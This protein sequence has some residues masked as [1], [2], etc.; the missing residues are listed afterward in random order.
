MAFSRNYFRADK[1][2][3]VI[4][5]MVAITGF[6]FF[7]VSNQRA[8]LNF[9]YIPVLFSAY[10][11]G[12]R[13]AT[14]SSL[15]SLILIS[16]L[17]FYYPSTFT[18]EDDS[19]FY[20]W[21]DLA[22]W[23]GFL[24]ITGYFMGHLYEK[25]ESA[26][27]EIKKT[28]QGIIEMM[29]LIIDSTDKAAQSHSYKVS[30]ISGMI[31]RDMGLSE[32]WVENIRIAALLHDL[33]KLDVGSEVLTKLGSL[34]GDECENLQIRTIR[35]P[36]TLEPVCGKILDILPLILYHNEKF[37]G[38]GKLGMFG[39]NI[40]L[41]ARIIAVAD[42]FDYLI[43]HSSR[44][45]DPKPLNV[46]EEIVKN[47]DR[48]FDPRVVKAFL[49]VYP[50]FNVESPERFHLGSDSSKDLAASLKK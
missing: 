15:F 38:S 35:G 44:H 50:Q 34:P 17:A 39:E 40:P 25:K 42:A 48:H 45:K 9:F 2:L 46:K 10:F 22:T 37:D 1:E 47:A 33:E 6:L 19:F 7:F 5:L 4:F 28:Y 36:D 49:S 20:K 12:K 24:I 27:R 3:S 32:T 14:L 8:F 23:G 21:L 11:F 13:H 16:V 26:N 30:V 43:Y 18:F 29:S 31:A 41:G